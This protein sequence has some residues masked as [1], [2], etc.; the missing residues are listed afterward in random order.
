[1]HEIVSMRNYEKW[2]SWDIVYEWEDVFSAGMKM[3]I[4]SPS[5]ISL[6]VRKCLY[7][8]HI[9]DR[10]WAGFKA[11]KTSY[12]F[13]FVM[14][15]SSP[16]LFSYKNCIPIFLDTPSDTVDCVIKTTKGLPFFIVTNF[17]FYGKLEKNGVSNV[18]YM[19]LSIP[20]K[21]ITDVMPEKSLDVLQFGRKNAVLHEWMLSYCR[22]HKNVEYVY[23]TEDGSL[24][25][26]S[27]IRGGV[28][29][30]DSRESYIKLLSSARVS[31]VSSPG[32]DGGRFGDI[33]FI[34]P[35]FYESAAAYC[36]LL[37]RYTENEESK[38]VGIREICENVKSYKEFE[39]ALTDV[40]SHG[41]KL[42]MD[43]YKNFLESNKTSVRVEAIKHQLSHI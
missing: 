20:D 25:Y 8:L 26:T 10:F 37:G 3:N 1:M 42:D 17:D 33:D 38:I 14:N 6:F 29:K 28:G 31:L 16:I 7:H 18:I 39:K 15:S 2:P 36:Y 11:D 23:Q 30:F 27:T 24:M 9:K 35:R 22:E 19:P 41:K 12:N 43:R 5:S 34:T 40:L 4:S 13:I 21:W 32:C